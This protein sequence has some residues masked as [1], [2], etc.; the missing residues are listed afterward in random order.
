[1][2]HRA[3]KKLFILLIFTETMHK[4]RS[5]GAN[6]SKHKDMQRDKKVTAL[7]MWFLK[8]SLRIM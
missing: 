7:L 1:M 4:L 6:I 5:E 3:H 2:K 8:I